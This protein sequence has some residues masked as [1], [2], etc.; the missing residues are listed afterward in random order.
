[1]DT[2]NRKGASWMATKMI[3]DALKELAENSK[4]SAGGAAPAF[5]EEALRATIEKYNTYVANQKD[6]DF[7]KEV[8]AEKWRS[9]YEEMV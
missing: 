5:S 6:D 9:V 1:M 3:H 7:G 8:L 2:F 4:T